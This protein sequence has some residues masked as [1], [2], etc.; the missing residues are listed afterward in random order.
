MTVPLR[1]LLEAVV[2]IVPFTFRIMVQLKLV[3]VW[4]EVGANVSSS[5]LWPLSSM[6]ETFFKCLVIPVA[7]TCLNLRN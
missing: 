5:L 4:C 1:F 2:F 3:Y 7:F 6:L